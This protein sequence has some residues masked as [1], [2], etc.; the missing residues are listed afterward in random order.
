MNLERLGFYVSSVL[1][2]SLNLR[3]TVDK[4]IHR[5]YPLTTVWFSLDK[6]NS[7]ESH[8]FSNKGEGFACPKTSQ[9]FYS[10]PFLPTSVPSSLG[11]V[12]FLLV[13]QT[14]SMCP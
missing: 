5:V 1:T 8:I 14:L 2:V 7:P 4:E 3:K 9:L 6:N 12:S 13:E 10:A 11:E